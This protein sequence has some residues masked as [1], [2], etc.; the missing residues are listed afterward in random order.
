MDSLGFAQW[1]KERRK[2]LDITQATLGRLT[3]CSESSI[4]KIEAGTLKPSRQVADL[5]AS[6]LQVPEE[7]RSAFVQWA[8]SG[9][10]AQPPP[11]LQAAR[12]KLP[13]RK[14]SSSAIPIPPTAL[15]GREN[16]VAEVLAL[17]GREGV[18]LLTLT[19]PPGMGKTRLA[20]RVA[21]DAEE[22]FSDGVLFVPLA[23]INDPKLVISTIS[24]ASGVGE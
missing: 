22:H 19:G 1:L 8:R 12:T 16:E 13:I 24:R 9:P 4:R 7:E 11:E 21:A 23:H 14:S 6:S 10:E 5:L 17:L 3:G 15:I 20:L 2:S 18:R